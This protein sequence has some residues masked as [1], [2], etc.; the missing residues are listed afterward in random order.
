LACSTSPL[1]NER[2]LSAEIPRNRRYLA[3]L[4]RL[5]YDRRRDGRRLI[6]EPAFAARIQ[7]IEADCD[8]LEWMTLRALTAKA[9]GD[10]SLPVGSIMKV[11]GSELL[12]KTTEMQIE[13]LGDQGM[14][15]HRLDDAAAAPGPDKAPGLLADFLYRRAKTIYGGADETQRTI[16][17]KQFLGL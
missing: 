7:Q 2:A 14:Y 5:A 15:V 10:L 8:A 9:G 13:A 17:A 11:R 16:I 12:Q 1:E 4:K 3:T 6:D